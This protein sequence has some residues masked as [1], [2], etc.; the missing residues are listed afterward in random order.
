MEFAS[1]LATASSDSKIVCK[2]TN[3][4]EFW[5]SLDKYN[6]LAN[7]PKAKLVF[8]EEERIKVYSWLKRKSEEFSDQLNTPEGIVE[9]TDILTRFDNGMK[10]YAK[11][12]KE[13]GSEL[14]V[15]VFNCYAM[16]HET[17]KNDFSRT[18]LPTIN[19]DDYSDKESQLNS[20]VGNYPFYY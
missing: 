9:V 2:V 7:D 6:E 18:I 19:P 3:W 14:F 8:A 20:V 10:Q 15:H 11:F 13:H 4:D 12:Y 17:C 16:D 5:E 1:S